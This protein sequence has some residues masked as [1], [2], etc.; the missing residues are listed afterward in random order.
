MEVRHP[1]PGHPS[2]SIF[3]PTYLWCW[4]LDRLGGNWNRLDILVCNFSRHLPIVGEP[5]G[6]AAYCER[7]LQSAVLIHCSD[8]LFANPFFNHRIFL[9]KA[10]ANS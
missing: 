6:L 9:T 7:Y 3:L 2:T 10:V 5:T 1:H 4:W 8:M